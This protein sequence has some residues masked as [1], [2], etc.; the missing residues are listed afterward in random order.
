MPSKEQDSPKRDS[1][2]LADSRQLRIIDLFGLLTLVALLCAMAAPIIRGL[3]TEYRI[4]FLA[5]GFFQVLITIGLSTWLIRLRAKLLR[6][7]GQ[8]LGIGFCGQIRWKHW[9]VSKSVLLMVGLAVI[10]LGVAVLIIKSQS[11]LDS[12]STRHRSWIEIAPGLLSANL[13]MSF[14]LAVALTRNLW[15]VY[16]NSIEFFAEGVSPNCFTLIKWE[17]AEIQPSQFFEDRVVV[18]W[19]LAKGSRSGTTMVTQVSAEL[20]ELLLSGGFRSEHVR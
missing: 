15:R 7:S 18:M 4:A 3:G 20:K 1:L 12:T 19:R 6:R 13:Q 11:M 8:R 14:F 16:P 17:Q 9:P 2:S 10:Q 5:F